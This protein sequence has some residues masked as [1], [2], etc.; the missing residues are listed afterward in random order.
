[1][2]LQ[3]GNSGRLNSHD[4]T[5]AEW[6]EAWHENYIASTRD[7]ATVKWHRGHL[8]N[9]IIPGIGHIRLRKLTPNDLQKFYM[10]TSKVR[11][12]D[13]RGGIASGTLHRTHSI[14]RQA[15]MQAYKN[16]LISTNPADK[17]SLPPYKAYRPRILTPAEAEALL[18]AAEGHPYYTAFALA[19]FGGL[20]HGEMCALRWRDVDFAAGSITIAEAKTEA[21]RREVFLPPP[22]MAHLALIAKKDRDAYVLTTRQLKTKTLRML[23]HAAGLPNIR[24]HDLRHTHAT[25]LAAANLSPRTIADR[26]GHTD[27]TFTIRTYAH[28]SVEA[29]RQA[30]VVVDNILK[31][32]EIK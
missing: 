2:S 28:L 32:P 22:M 26:I 10:A 13:K 8:D 6:L 14:I 29:Q 18:R 4:I 5:L 17:V 23:Y 15:L 11:M 31:L 19:L 3:K 25:W 27:P 24:V 20:R 16:D 9:R 21:G 1:M 12:D 7:P 30:S